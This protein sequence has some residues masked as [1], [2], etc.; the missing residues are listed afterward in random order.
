MK[1][2]I[3]NYASNESTQPLYFDHSLKELNHDCSLVNLGDCSVFDALDTIDPEFVI[4]S[5]HRFHRHLIAYLQQ[6]PEKNIKIILNVDYISNVDLD[7]LLQFLSNQNV[8]VLFAFTS[9]YSMPQ[10]IGRLNVLKML[11]AADNNEIMKT[12]FEYRIDKAIIVDSLT[13]DIS[14]SKSFHVVSTRSELADKVDICSASVA[15]RGLYKNYDEVIIKDMK[16]ISQVFL[17]AIL[18]GNKVYYDNKDQDEDL[19][20]TI[21]NIFKLDIDLNYSSKNKTTNFDDIKKAITEKH[22]GLNRT[23]TLL[24]QIKGA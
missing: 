22:L 13:S 23:K 2:L 11:P 19:A 10:T 8:D 5:A 24:S 18:N 3:D 16:Q 12:D 4:I 15:L 14:D 9:N 21:N 17:E 6:N 1:F 20:K 7:L